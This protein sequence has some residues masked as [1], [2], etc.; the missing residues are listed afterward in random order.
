M[1][2]ILLI[3][4]GNV[5]CHIIELLARDT[6]QMEFF[7][8]DINEEK[9]A[10]QLNNA[11]IGAAHHGLHPNFHAEK[12]DLNNI[13]QTAER[14]RQIQ[15]DV[16]INCA[17]IHTWHLIRM[18]P[19]DVYAKLSSAT[20]GAWLPVQLLLA[21]KVALAIKASGI[22]AH[23][24]NTSLSDLTNPVLGKIGLAPTVGVGNVDLIAPAI[25][26]LAAQELNVNRSE[27][28]VSLV[29]HHQH[30]VVP[31]EAGYGAGAPY[32]LKIMHG[33]QNITNQFKTDAVMHDAVKLYPPGLDF[34]LV[35]A[36]STIKNA[37]ALMSDEP[38]ATHAPGPLGL[39]GG[40]PVLINSSGAELNLPED[41]S[42]DEAVAL[43]EASQK[44]DGVEEIK[45]DGTVIFVDYAAA[46]MKEMLGFD[47]P[48]FEPAECE[49]RAKELLS[50]YR[51]FAKK[52]TD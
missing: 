1:N 2:K 20:L 21:Y 25:Q 52:Y 48:K 44:L 14:I 27:I 49:E 10:L 30:W 15:P 23:Y 47:C 7:V 37:F 35:T 32:F 29:A 4:T 11:V 12:M 8:A 26:T 19:D 41:I 24:I 42:R 50:L 36:S 9:A 40:Y 34:T 45:E 17:V 51:A 46:I 31:R 39:P 3:G 43:N 22:T 28:S 33:D 13:D 18:L 5:G 6:R 38:T 16:I